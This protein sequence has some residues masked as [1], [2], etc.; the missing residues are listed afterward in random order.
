[1]KMKNKINVIVSKHKL[2]GK[3]PV[4]VIVDDIADEILQIQSEEDR[5][6]YKKKL[7][8]FY[9]RVLELLNR[10]LEKA[11]SNAPRQ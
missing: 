10:K 7:K 2:N 6:E 11:K 3:R 9:N 1:M 5:V 8:R 4:S